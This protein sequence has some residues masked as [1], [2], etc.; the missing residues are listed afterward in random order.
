M[1]GLEIQRW[2]GALMDSDAGGFLSWGWQFGSSS[3]PFLGSPLSLPSYMP[4]S[5]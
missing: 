4:K 5:I 2:E 3:L 1:D